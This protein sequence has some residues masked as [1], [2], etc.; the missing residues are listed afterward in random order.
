MQHSRASKPTS[1]RAGPAPASHEDWFE[2]GLDVVTPDQA[3]NALADG[4]VSGKQP[5]K[6]FI[7][8]LRLGDVEMSHGRSNLH[9]DALG[10][11]VDLVE[12]ASQRHGI[13]SDFKIG[14]AH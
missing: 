3:L 5:R 9:R 10:I 8:G 2:R 6:K 1:Y 11:L 14:R 13:A 7:S 4:R 12:R